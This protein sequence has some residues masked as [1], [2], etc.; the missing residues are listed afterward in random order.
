ML[1]LRIREAAQ[2][3]KMNTKVLASNS[4]NATIVFFNSAFPI[5]PF[6]PPLFL[7]TVVHSWWR[8]SVLRLCP[9][10]C[11]SDRAR[12]RKSK[13]ATNV[14][15]SPQLSTESHYP[16]NIFAGEDCGKNF[17]N[18]GSQG[19]SKTKTNQRQVSGNK[20]AYTHFMNEIPSSCQGE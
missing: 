8:N 4:E 7:P 1:D 10:I 18:V 5:L 16:S 9:G 3:W 6:S 13:S 20:L 19:Q 15:V 12:D 11:Q 14:S 2:F 17:G